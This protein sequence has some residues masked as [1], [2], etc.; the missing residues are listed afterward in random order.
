VATKEGVAYK[1]KFEWLLQ[2]EFDHVRTK[3]TSQYRVSKGHAYINKMA[4]E[5]IFRP[6]LYKSVL[7][8]VFCFVLQHRHGSASDA[9]KLWCLVSDLM[10]RYEYRDNDIKEICDALMKVDLKQPVHLHDF[11]FHY[12]SVCTPM[13]I[14]FTNERKEFDG[15]RT[16]YESAIQS[17]LITSINERGSSMEPTI[18]DIEDLF[19]TNVLPPCL[20]ELYNRSR[21]HMG[22]MDR[23]NGVRYLMA[24][25]AIEETCVKTICH[26]NS[27]EGFIKTVRQECRANEKKG[28]YRTPF[29]CLSVTKLGPTEKNKFRCFYEK[30]KN[31]ETGPNNSSLDERLGFISKCCS[32]NLGGI[33]I[34]DPIQYI[35]TKIAMK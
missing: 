18:T 24:L 5:S 9:D 15:S 19:N 7:N 30:Q 13:M 29:S 26:E 33:Q 23:M 14:E 1:I 27:D 25:S 35:H 4:F 21:S 8:D 17:L 16:P 22:Y 3:K 20:K 12:G 2:E 34:S 11:C 10:Y 31:G 32:K 28:G 6:L